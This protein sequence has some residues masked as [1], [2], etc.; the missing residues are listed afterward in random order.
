MN[1]SIKTTLKTL[2]ITV[3]VVSSAFSAT[4]T[5]AADWQPCAVEGAVCTLPAPGEVRYGANDQYVMQAVTESIACDNATFDDPIWCVVKACEYR[6]SDTL[7]SDNDGTVDALD[8]FPAD[9]AEHADS[10]GDGMGD[11]SDPFP[12]DATNA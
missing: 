5:F 7:D 12:N 4:G 3:G 10:D 9:P 1:T 8:A 2:L 6:L 11:N